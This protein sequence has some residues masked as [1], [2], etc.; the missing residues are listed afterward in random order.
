MAV[1]QV[2]DRGYDLYIGL[3]SDTKPASPEVGARFIE[4]DSG[5]V[6]VWDGTAWREIPNLVEQHDHIQVERGL[7]YHAG[8][9]VADGSPVA[10]DAS[11]ELW[12]DV[13]AGTTPHISWTFWAGGLAQGYVYEGPTVSAEGT[14]I[15]PLN[16]DRASSNTPGITVKHTPTVT[17]IGTAIHDGDWMGGTAGARKGAGDERAAQELRLAPSTTYLWRL[18][19]RVNNIRLGIELDWYEHH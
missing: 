4:Y 11:I 3:E 16:R 9:S 14:T 1:I 6:H 17:D 2:T 18:T 19:A 5:E 7:A 8:F 13:P 10:D 15:T 12:V